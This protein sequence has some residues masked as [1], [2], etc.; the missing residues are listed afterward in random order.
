MGS[1]VLASYLAD[2]TAM[3]VLAVVS[4]FYVLQPVNNTLMPIM[5]K[6]DASVA[7][8]LRVVADYYHVCVP[9]MCR[10]TLERIA[11]RTQQ[12]KGVLACWLREKQ[13]HDLLGCI[14]GAGKHNQH[15]VGGGS[16]GADS[17]GLLGVPDHLVELAKHVQQTMRAKHGRTR[18]SKPRRLAF[19]GQDQCDKAVPRQSPTKPAKP[20]KYSHAKTCSPCS[21]CGGR[22]CPECQMCDTCLGVSECELCGGWG[23]VPV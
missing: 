4:L 20:V 22:C 8:A 11:R 23:G 7:A 21:T 13:Q 18:I 6:S 12:G 10:L 17:A 9:K 14:V 3:M 15:S 5:T 1:P 2:P 19:D 16:G